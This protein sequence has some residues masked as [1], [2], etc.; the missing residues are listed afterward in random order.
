MATEG[1]GGYFEYVKDKTYIDAYPPA[2]MTLDELKGATIVEIGA[3][4]LNDMLLLINNGIID[5]D[6]VFISEPNTAAFCEILDKIEG[7]RGNNYYAF[8]NRF[9]I[10]SKAVPNSEF[11]DCC[12]NF[13]YANN[14]LHSLGYKSLEDELDLRSYEERGGEKTARIRKLLKSP[15]E[16]VRDVMIDAFRLLKAGGIFFGRN[17]TDYVNE[18]ALAKLEAKA[19]KTKTDE[20]A[21]WTAKAVL[22]GTLIG[23]SP[24]EFASWAEQIGFK[25]AYTEEEPPDQTKPRR[26]FYFRFEK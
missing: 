11:P 5:L 4:T 10:S 6:H 16:K 19:V 23:V 21:I 9:R 15:E 25:K 24:D 8:R 13:V 18:D 20:F 26:N 3:G 2:I 1:L 17:L 12:A 14:V 7:L 22:D